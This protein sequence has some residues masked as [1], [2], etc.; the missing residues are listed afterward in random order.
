M[1]ET[2]IAV[3]TDDGQTLSQHFGQAANFKVITLRNDQVFSTELRPKASHRHGEH[4]H[5]GGVHPGQAM[6]DSIADCQVLIC[7]GMGSPAFNKAQS[8]GIQVILTRIQSIDAAI[9][10]FQA[11]ALE[12]DGQL[13]HQH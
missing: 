5:A 7:G 4:N 2:K 9:Q 11:G 1:I 3:P 12:H 8:A 6:V 10:A 13:I